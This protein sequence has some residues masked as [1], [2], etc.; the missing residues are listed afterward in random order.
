MFRKL[1]SLVM[2]ILFPVDPWADLPPVVAVEAKPVIDPETLPQGPLTL[3]GVFGLWVRRHYQ[4]EKMF[5]EYVQSD[6]WTLEGL[7]ARSALFQLWISAREEQIELGASIIRACYHGPEE[8]M[9]RAK[10]INKAI[11]GICYEKVQ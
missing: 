7:D 9:A 10:R 3:E 5:D 4:A 1:I 8:Y 2:S 11:D 6:D